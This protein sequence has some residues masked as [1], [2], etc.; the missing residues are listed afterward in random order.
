MNWM[1]AVSSSLAVSSETNTTTDEHSSNLSKHEKHG[2]ALASFKVLNP[3]L[4]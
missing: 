4:W 3:K 1:A 2:G